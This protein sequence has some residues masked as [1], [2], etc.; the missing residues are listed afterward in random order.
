MGL[1]D[2]VTNLP[3]G[4]SQAFKKTALLFSHMKK[5]DLVKKEIEKILPN[6]PL[7]E[8]LVHARLVLKWLLKLNPNAGELLQ[9]AA[10]AHDIDRAFT[11]ITEKDLKDYSR[12]NEFKKEH[13][14]RS[15]KFICKILDKQGYGKKEIEK[16]KRLVENHEVGGDKESG[17]LMAA[18]SIA[19]FEYNVPFYLKRNG[20]DNT[21]QKIR[22]M[23]N[24]LPEKAKKIVQ[25]IKFKNKEV[26]ELFRETIG[27]MP[28]VD[29]YSSPESYKKFQ[30]L[31]PDYAKA[32]AKSVELAGKH[33]KNH[34]NLVLAD[35][36]CGIGSNTKK[37][38]DSVGGIRKATLVDINA[39]FLNKA[40][41]SKIKAKELAIK[42]T[43]VLEAGLDKECDL[44]FSIFAYHHIPTEK[45]GKYIE[46][47]KSCLK[48]KGLLIL[49]EIY[50]QNKLEE[51]SY[52]NALFNSVPKNK[53]VPGLKKFLEQTAK[54][55]D[56]EFKVSKEFADKQF[57]EFGFVKLEEYKIWPL[58]DPSNPSRGAFVQVYR[59]PAV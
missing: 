30:N 51:I 59:A 22:F 54:S 38:A 17:L 48:P 24:R 4:S 11:G 26:A 39:G 2:A 57:L 45:K 13:A 5:F 25:K 44:V 10:L 53:V 12:I 19:Y 58:K 18:D 27:I 14:A 20:A 23:F 15:A 16:V 50:L 37:F 31:R 9:I 6:S 35:F 3:V 55:N 52:Y 47:I 32:I 28:D 29:A 36:C 42:Q 43:D 41:E 7:A 1:W 34:S 21:K 46:K 40:K 56:F 8:E 49:A 33:T